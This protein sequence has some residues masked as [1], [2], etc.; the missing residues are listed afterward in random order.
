MEYIPNLNP[1]PLFFTQGFI[2]ASKSLIT[3]E[4]LWRDRGGD[5]PN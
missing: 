1:E 4:N 3:N 2:V 5:P